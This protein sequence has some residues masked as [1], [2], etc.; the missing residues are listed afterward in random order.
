MVHAFPDLDARKLAVLRLLS[1]D[2]DHADDEI[3]TALA[4]EFG[5]TD[6]MRAERLSN[7]RPRFANLVDWAKAWLTM[8]KKVLRVGPKVYRILPLGKEALG[9]MERQGS[10]TGV[11]HGPE[12]T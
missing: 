6:D 7:G 4:V 3:V 5:I 2:K 10:K 11:D 9:A 8:E 1:D 12:G